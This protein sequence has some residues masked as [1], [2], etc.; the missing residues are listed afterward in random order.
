MEKCLVASNWYVVHTRPNSERRAEFH[1]KSQGFECC[2][3][4][5][6][7]TVKHARKKTTVMKPFFAR[8]LFISLDLEHDRWRDINTTVGVSYILTINDR[9]ARVPDGFVEDLISFLDGYQKKNSE[10]GFRENQKVRFL[11][12]P[13]SEIIGR[14]QRIDSKG[15]VK[16]LMELLGRPVSVT[17][18][19]CIL[20]ATT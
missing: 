1:L 11:D 13:F 4:C 16:V 19:S 15:R 18:S 10:H 12:G 20:M 7:K 14:V 6:E 3:P 2:L 9:P 5:L 17:T 8:Y